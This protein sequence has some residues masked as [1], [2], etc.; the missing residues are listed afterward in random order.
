MS[1]LRAG[2]RLAVG[3]LTVIPSG[4]V[5]T[6]PPVAGA[7]MALAPVATLPLALAVG[8]VAAL[9]GIAGLPSLASAGLVLAVLALGSRAMHLDGLADTVDGLGGGWTRERAL[10]IMRRGDVGPMGV[11]AL[12]LVLLVQAACVASLVQASSTL[13]STS[14]PTGALLLAAAVPLSRTACALLCRRGCV[15]ASTSGLGA[16]VIGTVRP[17]A[18]GLSV[19][20]SAGLLTAATALSDSGY[21]VGLTAGAVAVLVPVLLGAVA[22]R[23]LGGI[24]GDIIGAAV[25]LSLLAVLLVL[26]AGT[27]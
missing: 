21:V 18:V 8:V 25:E 14:V 19:L 17:V 16:A 3:T 6:A 12:L 27:A 11:V 20:A 15:A 22:T 2:L 26:A 13:G 10:E 7:A 24:T 9:G 1:L 4:P 5:S 23:R